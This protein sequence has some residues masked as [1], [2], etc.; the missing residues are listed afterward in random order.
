MVRR[1]LYG[2]AAYE[3]GIPANTPL[4][5]AAARF[6]KTLLPQSLDAAAARKFRLESLPTAAL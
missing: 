5:R 1:F 2:V 3:D 4:Y 6:G